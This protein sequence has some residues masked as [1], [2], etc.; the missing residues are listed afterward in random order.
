[1]KKIFGVIVA[2]LLAFQ[3]A[4]QNGHGPEEGEKHS[5]EFDATAHAIHHALDAHEFHF[6]DD[7]V[8]PLPVILWTNEGLVTFMSSEFHYNHDGT[9]VDQKDSDNGSVVVSKKGMNFVH[10]L[11]KNYQTGHNISYIKQ[12]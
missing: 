2:V 12:K 1:M 6:T 9:K 7:F 3:L 8:I 10:N 11:V 5:K 4:A